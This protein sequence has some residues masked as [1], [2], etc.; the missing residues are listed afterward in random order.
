MKNL[1]SFIFIAS[2]AGSASAGVLEDGRDYGFTSKTEQVAAPA[3]PAPSITAADLR[4]ESEGKFC[5]E[6]AGEVSLA[7]KA[8]FPAKFCIS[9]LALERLPSGAIKM[10]IVSD[11]SK[12]TGGKATYVFEGNALKS[13]SG[14]AYDAAEGSALKSVSG[15][16]HDAADERYIAEINVVAPVYPNGNLIPGA[17]IKIQALAAINSPSE[18]LVY[19]SVSY[20]KPL[21]PVPPL[22]T[23][24]CFT[25]PAQAMADQAGLPVKFCVAGTLLVRKN[26]GALELSVAGDLP[27]Q[28]KAAYVKKNENIFVQARIFSREEGFLSETSG[29]IDILVPTF[30]NGD[31]DPKGQVLVN[32]VAGYNSDTYHL[33]WQYEAVPYKAGPAK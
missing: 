11:S 25:R 9:K 13:I 18:G 12:I 32:A 2:V 33:S 24:P 28:F 26:D 15:L 23:G 3:V 10:N 22:S 16:A 5:F 19:F 27:G 31:V 7:K 14:L 29:T 4:G 1:L 6:L 30:A 20:V 17:E 8:G 21:P